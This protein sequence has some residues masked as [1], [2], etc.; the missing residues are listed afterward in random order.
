MPARLRPLLAL[1]SLATLVVALFAPAQAVEAAPAHAQLPVLD[2]AGHFVTGPFR[3]FVEAH[4]GI[5][6]FGPPLTDELRDSEL[7]LPVQYFAFARLELHGELIQL[8]R[9][10]SLHAASRSHEA[11]FQ[12]QS[13]APQPEGRVY[14]PE[15]GHTLGGAFAWYH[16][17]HGGVALLGYPI[18]EELH[19]TGPNGEPILMQYFERALLSYTPG[20][21]GT[22]GE[23]KQ[24]PLGAWLAEMV[25]APELRAPARPLAPLASAT[26][27]YKPGTGS[28]TNI[29]L[30]AARLDGAVVAPGAA[31]S[32]LASIGE[33][34]AATGYQPGQ[35]IVGGEVVEGE[36]GGGICLVSSALYRTFWEAGLPVLERRGHRLWLRAFADV[37]GLEAAV[38]T[39]GQD[40]RGRN[41]TGQQ[42]F[43]V[44]SAR[45]GVLNVTLWGRGDG[46]SVEVARPEVHQGEQIEVLNARVVRDAQGA[47]LRRERVRTVYER[48]P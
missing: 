35:A 12:W 11:A 28:A 14:V 39:P 10:G 46:R 29:E 21:D 9:L 33:V 32:F 5:D 16:R 37:P 23:V 31:L 19:E 25:V 13:E 44:A 3:S 47:L 17:S 36:I 48:V 7:G 15:S 30:A 8:T 26:L 24:F 6:A 1:F 4:G 38:Y 27:R 41:D 34:S 18:S 42:L 40:L 45:G 20:A 22:A 2:V 43:V